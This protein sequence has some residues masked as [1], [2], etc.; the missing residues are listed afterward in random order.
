MQAVVIPDTT[1]DPTW[2]QNTRAGVGAVICRRADLPARRGNRLYRC[3]E[4][5][6]PISSMPD[7]GTHCRHLPCRPRL[8]W[9]MPGFTSTR[10][11]A[12]QRQTRFSVRYNPASN[13]PSDILALSQEITESVTQEFASAHC[14][15]LA[16]KQE[17]THIVLVAQ[18]GSLLLT[19]PELPLDGLGYHRRR[20]QQRAGNLCTGCLP[21]EDYIPGAELSRCELAIPLLAGGQVIGVLNLEST[22]I[23]AFD[24]RARTVNG[25]LCRTG[26]TGFR[27]R[28]AFR[29]DPSECRGN[30]P[31]G[32]SGR[33]PCARSRN[34]APGSSFRQLDP[35]FTNCAR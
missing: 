15:S 29:Y 32:K 5:P 11:S 6:V 16:G 18:S 19:A 21:G 4:R 14:S 35:R 30:D 24:E 12:W 20:R 10:S 1:K 13:Q 3:N 27:K 7:I 8:R 22:Q 34:P 9:K 28:A 17:R 26:C 2:G 31:A 25:Y 33:T 23:N